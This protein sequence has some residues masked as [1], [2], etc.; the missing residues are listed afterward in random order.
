MPACH[1]FGPGSRVT[2]GAGTPEVIGGRDLARLRWLCRR[3]CKELDL[4]LERYLCG[5]Y[6]Y[7]SGTEQRLFEHLLQL[8]DDR[9]QGLL[10]G[11]SKSSDREW[12]DLAA[13]IRSISQV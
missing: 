9:L 8:P 7:A 4:L 12:E 6:G 1:G 10:L 5:A 11:L 2:D 3:G 13:K